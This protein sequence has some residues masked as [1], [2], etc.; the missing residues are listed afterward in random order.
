[1][2][3]ASFQINKLPLQI[4]F[5][6]DGLISIERYHNFHAIVD[7]LGDGLQA[8]I[9]NEDIFIGSACVIEYGMRYEY[10]Q[11][12]ELLAWLTA[13]QMVMPKFK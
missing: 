2:L 7:C 13:Q 5:Y 12:Q 6:E 9:S 4:T 3:Q 8:I 11:E 1:M 10:K